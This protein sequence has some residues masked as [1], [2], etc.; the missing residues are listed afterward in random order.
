MGILCVAPSDEIASIICMGLL[1]S[2]WL[3]ISRHYNFLSNYK[4]INFDD[5]SVNHQITL[6]EKAVSIESMQ[7]RLV[8]S[9]WTEKR[10]LTLE[11]RKALTSWEWLCRG[12]V[13]RVNTYYAWPTLL[14]FLI[15]E[16][17][18]CDIEKQVY[19]QSIIE[20]ANIQEVAPD[21]AVRELEMKVEG[22]GLTYMK[23][24]AFYDKFARQITMSSSI[25]EVQSNFNIAL[26]N[27]RRTLN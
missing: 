3:S 16:L 1:N 8:T 5:L 25:E 6:S 14:P 17:S 20:W 18:N 12:P 13:S 11:K 9:E 21:V 10:K 23:N 24:F 22:I 4:N 15:K 27:K 19:T 7:D 26:K 2:R